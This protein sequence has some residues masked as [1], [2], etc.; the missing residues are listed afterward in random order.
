M[1]CYPAFLSRCL[2][3]VPRLGPQEEKKVKERER[4]TSSPV[5]PWLTSTEEET[6]EPG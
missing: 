6:H 1:G 5:T 4:L 2:L 3:R